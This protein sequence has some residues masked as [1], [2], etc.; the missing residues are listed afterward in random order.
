MFRLGEK[1]PILFEILLVVLAFLAAAV[2]TAA[3]NVIDMHSGPVK[4][5][6]A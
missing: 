2:F 5:S 3:G 4:K 1:R 6:R